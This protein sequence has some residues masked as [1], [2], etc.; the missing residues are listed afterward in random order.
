MIL[1]PAVAIAI[2]SLTL[3]I[4]PARAACPARPVSGTRLGGQLTLAPDGHMIEIAA[5]SDGDAVVKLR[6]AGTGGLAAAFFVRSRQ[7]LRIGGL[8]DGDYIIQYAVG[9]S[10]RPDC[11]SFATIVR[12]GQIP[13]EDELRTTTS[14]TDTLERVVRVKVTYSLDRMA[15]RNVRTL[16]LDRAA[17]DAD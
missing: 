7:R 11:R 16:P 15:Q 12:S 10:L 8:P 13:Q 2:L 5:G 6:D 1:R 3:A 14:E 17:F 4:A 9:R